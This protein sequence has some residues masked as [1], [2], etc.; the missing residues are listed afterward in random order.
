MKY[1]ITLKYLSD[2]FPEHFA[3]LI[4]DEFEGD[5]Q[6]LDKEL[7]SSKR[8]G[9]YLVEIKDSNIESGG[10]K[11]I[12]HIE[13]QSSHDTNMPWRM[14]SY[15]VRIYEKYKLPVYQVVVYLNPDD[16]GRNVVDSFET[17]MNGKRIIRFNYEVLKVWEID[18]NMIVD[19]DLY[20]LFPIIPLI[21]QDLSDDRAY[22]K[23]CFDLV[24][25]ID[26]DDDTLKADMSICT[27]VLAGLKYPKDL[28]K[29]LMKVDI[30]RESV[31]YQ[32]ILNEGIEMGMEKGLETGMERGLETGME[33]GLEQGM[34]KS[35]ISV[36]SVR[37]G[38]VPLDIADMIYHTTNESR[39]DELLRLAAT[40]D[41]FSEFERKMRIY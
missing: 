19:N 1:D 37:F 40:T 26:I 25:N 31:I 24:D 3:K 7:L 36:L 32:D 12:L 23:K 4:F 14:L 15:Y 13:F 10:S 11:F 17:S 28:I 29:S 5:V 35:V 38:D 9:D 21:E 22:L 39:L 27:G 6:P 18:L 2:K 34:E 41:S 33:R 30:M 8:E 16:R 20:G